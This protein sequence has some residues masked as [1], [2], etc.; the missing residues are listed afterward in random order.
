MVKRSTAILVTAVLWLMAAMPTLAAITPEPNTPAGATTIA[1]KIVATPGTLLA[2]AFTE[3]PPLGTPN[4]W[5]DAPLTQ[6]PTNG[7]TFG[8]L[9]SGN[10]SN[11]DD[12]G[13]FTSVN[14]GGLAVHGNSAFDVTILKVDLTVPQSAN[15]LT[16]DF[17]F[18]SEEHPVYVGT[19]FNDA[20]IAELDLNTWTAV[21]STIT[22]PNNFAFDGSN[23]VVSINSTGV[24]GMT[25]AQGAGTAFDGSLTGPDTNGAATGLLQASTQITPGL[26]SVYFSI[27]DQGDRVLDSAVFLDNLRIGFVPNPSV[28]CVKGAQPVNF[29]MT[30]TPADETNPVG[31]PHTVTAT[32]TDENGTP[33]SGATIQFNVTGAHT[34]GGPG[35]TNASGE[36]TFTYTGANLGDDTITACYDQDADGAGE[37]TASAV[38]HWTV[39]SS[40]IRPLAVFV[41]GLLCVHCGND[42]ARQITGA[43]RTI[44]C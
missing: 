28:N 34:T 5:E 37:A 10:V 2:A 41:L 25:A 1:S 40:P 39:G 26:H 38:K 36:A 20:F 6:F 7:S 21:G 30:L 35:V 3:H 31:T 8:I 13:T 23:D 24:G 29:Q 33:V 15:C 12:P 18:L 32:L 16:F 27:F 42:L 17:K 11:V 43:P 22:A 14:D 4:G 19:Q 9:T 44:E